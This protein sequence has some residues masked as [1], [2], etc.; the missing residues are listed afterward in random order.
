M[1]PLKQRLTSTSVAL[2]SASFLASAAIPARAQEAERPILT[3]QQCSPLTDATLPAMLH[4]AEP[5]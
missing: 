1:R 2:L 3:A 4:G 5:H